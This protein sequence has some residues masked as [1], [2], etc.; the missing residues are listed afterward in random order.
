MILCLKSK[1]SD[2]YSILKFTEGLTKSDIHALILGCTELSFI[3][4]KL[5]LKIPILDSIDI[6]AKK[7]VDM[8]LEPLNDIKLNCKRK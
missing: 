7:A 8:A 4:S 6:L 2:S 3:R 1:N 5:S